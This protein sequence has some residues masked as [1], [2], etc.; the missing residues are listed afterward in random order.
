MSPRKRRLKYEHPVGIQS[1]VRKFTLWHD[2]RP[3]G[4]N[5]FQLECEMI[6]M[7]SHGAMIS[8][9]EHGET[10]SSSIE[11]TSVPEIIT[12]HNREEHVAAVVECNK[13]ENKLQESPLG[14]TEQDCVA[15]Y[16]DVVALFQGWIDKNTNTGSNNH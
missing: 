15:F 14:K 12:S 4:D 6:K 5:T 9:K 3:V 10:P 8:A 16:R 1:V 7:G 11:I 13:W 2:I